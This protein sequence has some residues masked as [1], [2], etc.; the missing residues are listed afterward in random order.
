MKVRP[1]ALIGGLFLLLLVAAAS[2]TGR[3]QPLS[4]D[5]AAQLVRALLL[6]YFDPP[7]VFTVSVTGARVTGDLLVLDSLTVGGRPVFLRG[8]EGQFLLQASDL[9]LEAPALAQQQARVRRV[10]GATLVA[11]ST[12][13][14][15]AQA[16]ARISSA[17]IEPR[18]RFHAGEFTITATVRRDDR[19]Y[20]TEARGRV[21]VE[22]ER[23]VRVAVTA[24]TVAG[25][26]VPEST[27]E[28]ELLKVNPVLDLSRYP[29]DL[30][31]RR[32]TLHDDRIELLAVGGR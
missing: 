2:S 8:I 21:I 5:A 14:A 19:L 25:G 32:L 11:G 22:R 7:S 28:R 23:I 24:M 20:P 4:D 18:I 3:S 10:G 16:L 9:A 1:A 15:M 17:I 31:I 12:A 26:A 6:R 30:R 29:L 27:V 13:A